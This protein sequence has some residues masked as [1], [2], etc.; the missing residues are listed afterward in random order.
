L[1]LSRQVLQAENTILDELLDEVH[2]DL[3]VLSM[4]MLDGVVRNVNGTLIITPK[5]SGLIKRKSKF[6]HQLSKP[7]NLLASQNYTSIL[8]LYR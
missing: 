2:V 1:L 8:S 6:S 3:D 5:S 7:K 4:L